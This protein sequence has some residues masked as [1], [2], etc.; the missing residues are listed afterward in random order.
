MGVGQEA[1]TGKTALR[2]KAVGRACVRNVE[3][4]MLGVEGCKWEER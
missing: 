3:Q 2:I 4:G 1:I